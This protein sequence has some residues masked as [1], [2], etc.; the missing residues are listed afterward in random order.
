MDVTVIH[1]KYLFFNRLDPKH[2]SLERSVTWRT[3]VRRNSMSW[4]LLNRS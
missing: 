1:F 2:L 3:K 4:C